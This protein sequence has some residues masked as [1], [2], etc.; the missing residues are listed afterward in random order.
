VDAPFILRIRMTHEITSEHVAFYGRISSNEKASKQLE[1]ELARI[2]SEEVA[3]AT[4]A[5]KEEN[6]RLK[7]IFV[8]G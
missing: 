3:L 7:G 2:V 8:E 1:D 4:K 5:L 6:D